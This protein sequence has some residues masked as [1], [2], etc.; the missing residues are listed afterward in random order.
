MK[1]WG[2]NGENWRPW[3]S[4]RR[5]GARPQTSENMLGRA[6]WCGAPRP[7]LQTLLWGALAG[8]APHPFYLENSDFSPSFFISKPSNLP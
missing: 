1:R 6:G 8:E 4:E 7:K 5:G 2:T 3:R